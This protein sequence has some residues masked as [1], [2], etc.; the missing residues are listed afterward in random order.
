ML[1]VNNTLKHRKLEIKEIKEIELNILKYI[2]KICEENNLE[3][4]L[5]EG[6]LLGAIRHRGFI[7]WD[8]DIDILMPR[9]DYTRLINILKTGERYKSLSFYND[10][11]YYYCF[12]KI[13]D[14]RTKVKELNLD[15]EIPNLGVWVDV[16]PMDGLPN[17]DKMINIH[18]KKILFLRKLLYISL[19]KQCPIASSKIKYI[20]KHVF[21]II[22]RLFGW[23]FWIN[24][25][26][27]LAMKYKYNQSCKVGRIVSGHDIFDKK[28]F[29]YGVQRIFED[30][31]FS[32]PKDYHVYLKEVFGDYMKLPP[33][34]ERDTG[35]V[36]DAFI[37]EQKIMKMVENYER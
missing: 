14:L 9:N 8:D 22:A 24:K 36:F 33:I 17:D 11:G 1:G 30:D 34:D 12:A 27:K 31:K 29:S 21:W 15:Y 37:I 4:Y 7:P 35:H 2:K 10:D 3:Y 26:D 23:K 20:F 19:S 16:F 13:V 6:T 32:V 18:M 25:V 28:I 5:A